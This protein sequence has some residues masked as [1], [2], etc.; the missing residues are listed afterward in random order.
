MALTLPTEH[1]KTP[2]WVYVDGGIVATGMTDVLPRN[3]MKARTGKNSWVIMDE[4]VSVRIEAGR[5]VQIRDDYRKSL[6]REVKV[7]VSPGRHTAELVLAHT[8]NDP[9]LFPLAIGKEQVSVLSGATARV[10]PPV[11]GTNTAR[12]VW[13]AI[14]FPNNLMWVEQ[15]LRRVEKTIVQYQGDPIVQELNALREEILA[16]PPSEPVAY[17]ALPASCGGPR[18]LDARQVR[19]IVDWLKRK[20][21]QWFPN[22]AG[23][24]V[25]DP[26]GLFMNLRSKVALYRARIDGLTVVAEALEQVEKN[27]RDE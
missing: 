18:E 8:G 3:V 22:V 5:V 13:P 4:G 6:Y 7:E 20:H 11:I 23:V 15:Q 25:G 10:K 24:T 17:V 27:R 21:W 1:K 2:Y 12:F 14:K 16:S 19:M 26:G 9:D